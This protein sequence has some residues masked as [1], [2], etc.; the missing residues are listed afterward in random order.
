M[1]ADWKRNWETETKGRHLRQ[2]QGA[3]T[4][5]VQEIHKGLQ[6]GLR[7]GKLGLRKFLCDRIVPGIEAKGSD[8][9]E[10]TGLPHIV[11]LENFLSGKEGYMEEGRKAAIL[12]Q[13]Q[14]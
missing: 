5:E 7:T 11:N 12:P 6:N 8:L 4:S 13:N 3:L 14:C 9:C 1:A 2:L 10:K